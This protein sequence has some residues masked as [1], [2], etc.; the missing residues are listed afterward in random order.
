MTAV[1]PKAKISVYEQGINFKQDAY[2]E[3]KKFS[4]YIPEQKDSVL[5]MLKR[6]EK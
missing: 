1:H 6:F 2:D 4:V 3:N 5:E